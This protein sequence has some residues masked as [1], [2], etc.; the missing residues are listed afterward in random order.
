MIRSILIALLCVAGFEA[1]A[2]TTDLRTLDTEYSAQVWRAVGRI[3]L[4]R[5]RA[6][7]SGTLIAPDLVLTAAHCLYRPGTSTLF[8]PDEVVFH[9]GLR[10]GKAVVSRSAED[11]AAH[12]AFDP[13]SILTAANVRNDVGLIRLA[14]P[15]SS[16]EIPSFKLYG[17]SVSPGPVSVVSYG[18]GRSETQSHQKECQLTERIEDILFFDCSAVP[19]TSGAPVFSHVN[20][21]GEIIAVVSGGLGNTRDRRTVGMMLPQRVAEVKRQMRMQVRGPVAKVRRL[22]VG[23]R[24]SNGAKFVRSK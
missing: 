19:G 14:E 15:I 17:G 2:Q 23:T 10:Q 5:G 8:K 18:Q 9:A 1:A 7:C 13:V 16:Y 24:T 22:G 20:G 12:E 6:T 21:R 11:I 3:D 4:G